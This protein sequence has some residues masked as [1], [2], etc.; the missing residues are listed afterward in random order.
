MVIANR[1]G[2]IL[3][4]RIVRENKLLLDNQKYVAYYIFLSIISLSR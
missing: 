4:A 2:K 3:Y 1:A